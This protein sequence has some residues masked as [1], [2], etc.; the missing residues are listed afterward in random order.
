MDINKMIMGLNLLKGF[1]DDNGKEDEYKELLNLDDMLS[2]KAKDD[3]DS[4]VETFNAIK[5]IFEDYC[6]NSDSI[7]Q[8]SEMI[9]NFD[10]DE[11]KVD[12]DNNC[13]SSHCQCSDD[14]YNDNDYDLDDSYNEYKTYCTN[15]LDSN[16]V[17]GL[18][19]GNDLDSLTDIISYT[20]EVLNK[21]GY[22]SEINVKDKV[23]ISDI[24]DIRTDAIRL[25]SDIEVLKSL[26]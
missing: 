24:L 14:E 26:I 15:M 21:I 3:F 23:M 17:F 8:L 6:K 19:E 16:D 20:N 7:I 12:E 11:F 13:C 10:L 18:S 1:S 22:I 5:D 9:K 25:K 4:E 2:N